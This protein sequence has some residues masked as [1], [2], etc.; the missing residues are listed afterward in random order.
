MPFCF[1]F[2]EDLFKFE[3]RAQ[4]INLV[5]VKKKTTIFI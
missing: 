1:I 2:E 3:T 5:E 4:R